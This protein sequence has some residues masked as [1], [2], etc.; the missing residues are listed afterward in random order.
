MT[1]TRLLRSGRRLAA[2]ALATAAVLSVLTGCSMANGG[3]T[4]PL[5]T[6]DVA[7]SEAVLDTLEGASV[8]E[9]KKA[10]FTF[11]DRWTITA[12][13]TEIGEI[14]GQAIYAIGD[15][16]SLFSTAGNLVGSEAEGYRVVH[17][18]AETYDYSNTPR[19]VIQQKLSMF[20]SEYEIQ[21]AEGK[22]V[23]S[24]KQNF[25]LTMNF[26]VKG[27]SGS[28]EYKISKAAFSLTSDLKIEAQSKDRSVDA[29]DAL[30]VAVIASEVEDAAAEKDRQNNSN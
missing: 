29:I 8:I 9:A 23:G 15:T 25:S 11:G 24:A 1:A 27:K 6:A 18:R 30:W 20:L 16:Y 14:R 21:D 19:G 13:G 7:D 12:D 10:A 3:S 2:T 28:E 5:V 22:A 4:E 17:H 26:A